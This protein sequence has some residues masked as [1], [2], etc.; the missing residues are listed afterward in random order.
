[1]AIELEQ[2]APLFSLKNQND[3]IV[4]LKDL[5]GTN[6]VLYFYPRAMTPGCTVQACGLRDTKNDLKK[7]NAVALGVSPDSVAKLQKFADKE[8][9]NFDLLSDEGHEIAEKY[10]V[11]G[12]KKFMGKEHFGI[13]RSTFIIGADGKIKKILSKVTTKTHHQDVIQIL[14]DIKSEN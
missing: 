1:M 2:K 13:I 4:A 8:N 10:G 6:V 12:K 5:K 9:L 7:L 3:E 11:W 14:R